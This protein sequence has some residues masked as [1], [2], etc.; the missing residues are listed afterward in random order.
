MF[1]IWSHSHPWPASGLICVAMIVQISWKVKTPSSA[2]GG[3][4]L[5]VPGHGA[6]HSW[7]LVIAQESGPHCSAQFLM[8]LV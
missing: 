1:A 4:S 3:G 5:K 7:A 6:K 2:A 8:A